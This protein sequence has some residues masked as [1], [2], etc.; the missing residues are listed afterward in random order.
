MMDL[1][2]VLQLPEGKSASPMIMINTDGIADLIVPMILQD[3]GR[4]ESLIE[5]KDLAER[6]RIRYLFYDPYIVSSTNNPL[7]EGKIKIKKTADTIKIF[8]EHAEEDPAKQYWNEPFFKNLKL[9]KNKASFKKKKKATHR[10]LIQTA[11]LN[12]DCYP[13]ITGNNKHLNNWDQTKPLLFSGGQ[14][15]KYKLDI[16]FSEHDYPVEYKLAVW[17]SKDK[18]IIEWEE[19]NNRVLLSPAGKGMQILHLPFSFPGSRRKATGVNIQLS[20]LRRENGWGS[21]DFLDLKTLIRTAKKC[22]LNLIQL[23]PINDT[24]A[25]YSASDSYPY[26]P[27]SSRA[28]NPI[29]LDVSKLALQS[30]FDIPDHYEQE[31]ERLDGLSFLD[32]AAVVKL[33]IDVAREIFEA[34]KND[35]TNDTSWFSFFD[36]HREWLVPYA[37]FCCLRDQNSTSDFSQWKENDSYNEEN[38]SSLASPDAAG[39]NDILYWYFVQYQLHEQLQAISDIAR[40]KNI[41]LK[42]D[43][44]IG[45]G[46]Y[47]VETWMYPQYFHMDMQTGAPPDF[48]SKT[49]QN[50]NFPTYNWDHILA[51]NGKLIRDRIAHLGLF[52][53]AVRI[54]HVLGL[55]RIWSIPYTDV[56]GTRGRF[57]P[58]V[59]LTEKD[60]NLYNINE[61]ARFTK[62]EIT[63]ETLADLF[64]PD[65][66]RVQEIFFDGLN[67]KKSFSDE[68]SIDRYFS[69][70]PHPVNSIWRKRLFDLMSDVILLRN[71]ESPE[72]FHFR[73][74]M[75]DTN[76]YKNLPA[77][78]KKNLDKLYHQYFYEL[79]NESWE[80][81]GRTK[82]ESFKSFSDMLLCAEDLGM[83]PEFVKPVLSSL[84][85]LSLNV[86]QMSSDENRYFSNPSNAPYDCV[87]M[88]G[89]HDM[90]TIRE[91]WESDRNRAKYFWEHELKEK[92]QL[93]EFCEPWISKR[94]IEMHLSSRA[95]L[96]I[97]LLQD[98]LGISGQLRRANPFEERINDPADDDHEWRYRMHLPLSD[99]EN[100]KAF[101]KEIKNM[102][103]EN[104]R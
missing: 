45:I 62:H 71:A 53:D 63:K 52:F 77:D 15:G 6:K 28:L 17:H 31:R 101:R 29:F 4:W 33:K 44:P 70:H 10:F 92:G 59:A 83:V 41:I 3:S 84:R 22:G 90:P 48:F 87:V 76:M 8:L 47:S 57:V 74:N 20:A 103:R 56:I 80:A 25:H 67:F 91:W 46:R 1:H 79:Q 82:L 81:G 32:H 55:F 95:M 13:C 21:G 89:T 34:V 97:F 98:L 66:A 94:M 49:G 36:L 85:I 88:P 86:F 58:A 78:E 72:D 26:S 65:T 64:G 38:I 14:N 9:K 99:I 23:L 27:I 35:F 104:M 40:K 54:D 96:R 61:P 2:F 19:G 37:A 69:E 12:K 5:H 68:R 7:A 50:W 102:I 16:S 24:T 60:F 30:G 39:Y 18:K 11:P 43:L 100:N 73:I 75:Q 42:A 51:D 93:P